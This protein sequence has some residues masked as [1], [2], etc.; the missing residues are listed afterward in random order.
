MRPKL[1]TSRKEELPI[2]MTLLFTWVLGHRPP[3]LQRAV[4]E[5]TMTPMTE[6]HDLVREEVEYL[7]L[8]MK[9]K[10]KVN[11]FNNYK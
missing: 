8:F 11:D 7:P 10:L 4:E 9:K 1:G 3:T 6:E 5:R 2:T